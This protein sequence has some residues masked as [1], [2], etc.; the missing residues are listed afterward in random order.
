M[1]H[2]QNQRNNLIYKN[3]QDHLYESHAALQELTARIGSIHNSLIRFSSALLYA[4]TY[5]SSNPQTSKF[6]IACRTSNNSI[7]Q[8]AN[9]NFDLADFREYFIPFNKQPLTSLSP[10]SSTASEKS[11]YA[12]DSPESLLEDTVDCNRTNIVEEPITP[13]VRLIYTATT[14]RP[15][16][17]EHFSAFGI[18]INP[19]R[20]LE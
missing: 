18:R 14:S 2:Q 15:P 17:P 12:K 13:L 3:Y 9:I 19:H 4:H 1:S 11:S 7:H 6:L 10:S 16:P 20:L 8:I 5:T